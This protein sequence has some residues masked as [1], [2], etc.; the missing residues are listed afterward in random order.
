MQATC[1]I[2][3]RDAR[4]PIDAIRIRKETFFPNP[5]R[6]VREDLVNVLYSFPSFTFWDDVDIRHFILSWYGRSKPILVQ[7]FLKGGKMTLKHLKDFTIAR[8]FI[9]RLKLSPVVK[10]TVALNLDNSTIVM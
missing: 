5:P 3:E 7:E 8:I 10:K 1:T 4:S 6:K 2:W 9:D